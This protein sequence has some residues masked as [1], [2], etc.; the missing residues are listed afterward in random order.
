VSDERPERARPDDLGPSLQ[1]AKLTAPELRPGAVS[2][3]PLIEAAR[4]EGCRVV[5]VT[6]PAGYGKS[7]LLAEWA[8]TE[9]RPVAWVSLDRF[10]DDP[11]ALLPALASAYARIS[12]GDTD[13]VADVRGV[14]VLGRAAPRLGSAFAATPNPF[15]LML[16][17]LHEL[18]S[19]A[20][21]DALSV[22][23]S[24]IPRGSQLVAASRAE[25]P[26]LPRLRASGDAFELGTGD[27]ALDAVAAQHIFSQAQVH[28]APELAA[29]VTERT[30]GWPVGLYLAALIAKESPAHVDTVAG[31][32][33]YVADYLYRV[34]LEQLPET[35]Q[36]FLRRTAV[37]DQL[38][39]PLCNAVL[40][41]SDA[42]A[43]LRDLEAANLFL[44]PLDRRRE[45]YRYHALFRE[46]LLAELH[47]AE[48]DVTMK[49]HLRAA[50][51]YESNG[52]SALALEHLL[53]TTDRDRCAAL[54][55]AL[56]IPTYGAGQ[57]TTV[58]RW[59]STI[60]DSGVETHAPLAVFAAWVA[61]LTGQIVEAQRWAAV[62]DAA[63]LAPVPAE[64]GSSLESARA[65]LRAVM[66]PDGADTMRADTQLA[67]DQEPAWSLWRDTALTLRG[68]AHLLVGD[69]ESAGALFAEAS[70]VATTSGN[71]GSITIS[72][73]ELA[74][75]AMDGEQWSEAAERLAVA[76]GTID[77]HRL[78]D[79]AM[80]VLAFAAAARHALH[81][82]DLD[83]TN[84][85]L[86]RGMRA[87]PVCTY[88]LPHVS[89]RL[90]LQLARVYIALAD[91]TTARHLLREIDDILYHRPNLG[92]LVDDVAELRQTLAAPL[93]GGAAGGPPVSPAELRLLPYLQTHL[94]V[95]EI[96]GRLFLSHNTV[97][98]QVASIYRKLGVSS[99]SEAVQQATA[100]G[101]LGA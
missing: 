36:Q 90:R 28:L 7:T 54:M 84:R 58:Q 101:L 56:I 43:Q 69:V 38:S 81:R 79:Y 20:C 34:T 98:S 67:V 87:R 57:I 14:S 16:D 2:R 11:A 40:E 93:P 51:W 5:G 23:I 44:V 78:H 95:P 63:A 52:S 73:S 89:V 75:L 12:P 6:A 42:Y 77:Q 99:R 25:Q 29:A 8:A 1:A 82:G 26:H 9:D 18:Q 72:E 39:G 74:L 100:R 88:M 15:V 55:A 61:V 65:M 3:R 24:A 31:D 60:G 80:S 86:A 62:V 76:L 32:D 27:L 66:C 47:R 35:T 68:E 92:A 48:P 33:R 22:V 53:N 83:D 71:N 17:D 13:L 96:A 4:S 19:P 94:T 21:H 70:Q 91:A 49:L 46:F 97:R 59:L 10:D 37:L 41:T 45:W 30:E 50:D 64:G 85:Q